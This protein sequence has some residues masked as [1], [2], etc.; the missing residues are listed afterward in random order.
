MLVVLNQADKLENKEV[1]ENHPRIN[2]D[3]FFVFLES[4]RGK[5]DA[6]V[7]TGG[8]PTIHHDL[9]EFV[10][11]IKDLGF[12]VK[13]DTNGTN[14]ESVQ[15]LLDLGLIDYIAMDIKSSP[16]RYGDAVGVEVDLDKIRKSITII[17]N[18]NLPY[19]FR[20]TVVPGLVEEDDIALMGEMIQGADKWY[21]QQF[22]P[23]TDLIDSA[24]KDIQPHS[25]AVLEK[26]RVI[27]SG[28]VGECGV[29]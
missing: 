1:K 14:P 5:L 4:R 17:K 3:D 15:R 29:R 8:E 28:F 27:G 13:L 2:E 22:K 25:S 21:L 6:V 9:P 10:K 18:S 7:I 19:E 12:L 20:T 11:K 24:F 26:M 23:D 16:A